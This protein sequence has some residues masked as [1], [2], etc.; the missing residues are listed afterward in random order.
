M[1]TEKSRKVKNIFQSRILE[2]MGDEPQS[3]FAVK[4]GVGQTTLSNWINNGSEPTAGAILNIVEKCGVSADWFLGRTN[5]RKTDKNNYF[6]AGDNT[7][8]INASVG[9]NSNVGQDPRA[10]KNAQEL[11]D[12]MFAV[13]KSLME[14]KEDLRVLLMGQK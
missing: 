13:E 12:R 4:I 8:Q 7:T 9:S 2:L 5:E 3:R 6:T 14:I 10:S 1:S 11:L